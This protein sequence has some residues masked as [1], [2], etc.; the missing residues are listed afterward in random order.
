MKRT[1]KPRPSNCWL[2]RSLLIQGAFGA[3]NLI[4]NGSFERPHRGSRW[5]QNFATGSATLPG[6]QVVGA[7]GD[8]SVISTTHLENGYTWPAAVGEQWLDLTGDGSNSRHGSAADCRHDRR[9]GVHIS[10]FMWET[11]SA[12]PFR[13]QQHPERLREWHPDLCGHQLCRGGQ[14][15]IFGRSTPPLLWRRHRET[16]F[17]FMNGDGP[18]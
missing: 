10:L 1:M 7:P 4:Q 5:L 3:T 14:T 18:D 13:H 11:P 9:H 16:T 12:D 2:P 17:A 8:V 15:S 6:W